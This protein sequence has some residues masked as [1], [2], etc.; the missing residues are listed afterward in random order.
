MLFVV[1]MLFVAQAGSLQFAQG[2]DRRRSRVRIAV[3]ERPVGRRA[4]AQ[5]PKASLIVHAQQ[6]VPLKRD[7]EISGT[8]MA[9]G[10]RVLLSFGA[11]S[12]DPSQC[13]RPD[14]IDLARSPNRH[15]AFG[16]GNH[17]CIGASLARLILEIGYAEFLTRIPEFTVADGFEPQ[18]ETGNTRH[19]I[20]LPIFFPP[21]R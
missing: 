12:R 2:C 17:S 14:E 16:A 1:H 11:A 3:D 13:E 21:Q 5:R 9:P 19:M 15:L 7:V 10:D 20:E 8:R 18:Y 6:E 4:K